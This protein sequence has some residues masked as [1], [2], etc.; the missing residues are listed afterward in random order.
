MKNGK[1]R[2]FLKSSTLQ[3]YREGRETPGYSLYDWL[4]GY[5]YGRWPYLY[6]GIGTGEHPI[7][8]TLGPLVRFIAGLLP[9][10]TQQQAQPEPE[11]VEGDDTTLALRQHR[12][13]R[14]ILTDAAVGWNPSTPR[15]S[16]DWPGRFHTRCR[17]AR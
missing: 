11:L 14:R 16:C 2:R 9:K 6:I 8:K 4:H 1:G 13:H 10:H 12:D 3:F 7:A 5:V 17:R 15:Q